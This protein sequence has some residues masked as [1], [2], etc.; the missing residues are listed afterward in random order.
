MESSVAHPIYRDSLSAW[1]GLT[2]IGGL[3]LRGR[4]EDLMYQLKERIDPTATNLDAALTDLPTEIFI[5]AFFQVIQPFAMMFHDILS[6][7]TKAAARQGPQQWRLSVQNEIIELRNFEE[8]LKR[9]NDIRCVVDVPAVDSINAWIPHQVLTTVETF[10]SL[11]ESHPTFSR[12]S[13]GF[14]DVDHWL[15]EYEAGR[16][17]RFPP[18]LQPEYLVPGVDDAAAI[19]IAALEV[20]QSQRLHTKRLLYDYWTQCRGATNTHDALHPCAIAQNETDHWLRNCVLIIAHLLVSSDQDKAAFGQALG[21][22][23]QHFPRRQIGAELRIE[24]LERLLSLPAWKKRHE[25]YAVWVATEMVGALDDDHEVS[26][27]HLNGE[28]RFAFAESRIAEVRSLRT[29]VSLISERR[30]PLENPVGMS[31]ESSVQPDFGLWTEDSQ[32][33]ECIMVVEVKHYKRRSRRNFHDALVDYATAHYKAKVLLVN[34]GPVGEPFDDLPRTVRDRCVMLEYLDPQN[35]VAREAF[36]SEVRSRV[37]EPFV[38]VGRE[39]VSDNPEVVAIDVSL[40][41]TATLDCDW[42][43]EFLSGLEGTS[44]EIVLVDAGIRDVVNAREFAEWRATNQLYPST[45]LRGPVS[46]IL[47]R[48]ERVVVVTDQEGL[49]SLA[50]IDAKIEFRTFGEDPEVT[51]LQV[52]RPGRALDDQEQR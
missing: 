5:Q 16:Y 17:T 34:Y 22:L 44:S 39:G 26:I 46:E 33:D 7:F 49:G 15:G 52:S 14:D 12:T 32:S 43:S 20:I 24:D 8:F 25:T 18:S 35:R 23:Y 29:T 38:E 30:T 45:A 37:G 36:R 47:R 48:Y 9:W 28:L 2:E 41:M 11:R 19:A 40:S 10:V 51:L 31:R 21:R 3:D 1:R 4:D 6:F 42:F 13:T 27:N 50:R